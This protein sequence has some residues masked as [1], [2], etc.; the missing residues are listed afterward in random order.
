MVCMR[1]PQEGAHYQRWQSENSPVLKF[2]ELIMNI[3]ALA[4]YQLWTT[5]KK[6]IYD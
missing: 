3:N 5:R 4:V 2:Y 6:P 1:N